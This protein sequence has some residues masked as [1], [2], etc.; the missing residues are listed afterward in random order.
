VEAPK[1]LEERLDGL[2]TR[3]AAVRAM[4]HAIARCY[5]RV[6]RDTTFLVGILHG[7]GDLYILTRGGQHPQ[8]FAD[9]PVYNSIARDWDS[10]GAKALLQT[11]EMAEDAVA[12]VRDY[13]ELG[14]GIAGPFDRSDVLTGGYLL[15]VHTGRPETIEL[16]LQVVAAC[17]RMK[18]DRAS[19]EQLI[20]ESQSE[21]EALRHARGM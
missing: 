5:S 11:W 1:G 7:I 14:R 15:A 19:Y 8:P 12:A 20:A 3:S 4:S 2:W 13:D 17:G 6:N 9:E 18:V 16:K 21:I 10:V